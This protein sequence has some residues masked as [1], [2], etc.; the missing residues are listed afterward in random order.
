MTGRKLTKV[1][2]I[3][4]ALAI[5]GAISLLMLN[6]FASGQETEPSFEQEQKA[7]VT[8]VG[9]LWTGQYSDAN[10]Q[11]E[12]MSLALVQKGGSITGQFSRMFNGGV[13][14][15]ALKGKVTG[16]KL[17]FKFS[18]VGADRAHVCKGT[19]TSTVSGNSMTGSFTIRPKNGCADTGEFTLSPGVPGP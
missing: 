6:N 7:T 3:L 15:Y 1:F 8:Q 5:V 19:L 16:T 11:N 12:P 14:S 13:T 2:F 4:R 10:N 17:S 9:G 18:T